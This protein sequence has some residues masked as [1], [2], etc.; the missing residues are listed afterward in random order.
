MLSGCYGTAMRFA[1]PEE[2]P[3]LYAGT[4]FD[5]YSLTEDDLNGC[6]ATKVFYLITIPIDFVIDTILLPYDYYQTV[7]QLD[8]TESKEPQP[9][10]P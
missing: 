2:K 4:Q 9:E 10:K 5:I 3:R 8:E 6:V 7:N 1:F